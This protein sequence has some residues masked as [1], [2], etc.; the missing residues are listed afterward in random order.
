MLGRK[1]D[2]LK[3]GFLLPVAPQ[4]AS[5]AGRS[6]PFV[7]WGRDRRRQ[8]GLPRRSMVES[9][10]LS[11]GHALTSLPLA[12][13]QIDVC[14]SMSDTA[15]ALRIFDA[16]TFTKMAVQLPACEPPCPRTLLQG[17]D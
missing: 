15:V 11:S 8:N 1:L 16:M 12:H 17:P 6:E 9:A 4:V 13:V 2:S 3:S 7:L 10:C 5:R 14:D